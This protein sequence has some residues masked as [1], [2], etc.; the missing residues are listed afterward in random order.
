MHVEQ[1]D[2]F[3]AQ[4]LERR[5]ACGADISRTIVD[6]AFIRTGRAN[7]AELRRDFQP[8]SLRRAVE[9]RGDQFF[10]MSQSVGIGGIEKID[11]G[12][13]GMRQRPPN[14]RL[15]EGE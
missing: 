15:L 10:V 4:P 13:D 2:R 6:A 5:F 7:D 3:D 8:A 11:A 14:R 9:N 12:I 1:I